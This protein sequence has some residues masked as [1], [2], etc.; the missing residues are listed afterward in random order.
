MVSKSIKSCLFFTAITYQVSPIVLQSFSCPVYREVRVA[1]Q[2]QIKLL[3]LRA[4][5]GFM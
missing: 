2:G 3:M 4:S 1:C 5:L